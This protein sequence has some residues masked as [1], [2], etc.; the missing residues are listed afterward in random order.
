[1]EKERQNNTQSI[2]NIDAL[3][4]G[5]LTSDN[6][7]KIFSESTD[8]VNRNIMIKNQSDLSITL[9]YVDGMANQKIINDNIICPLTASKWYENCTTLSQ[10]FSLSLDGALDVSFIKGTQSTK[11]AVEAIL[12]GNTILVFDKLKSAIIMSTIGFDKRAVSTAMEE[13]TY[14][15]GKDGF[16]ETLRMNT[17]ALRKKIKNPNLCIKEITIG[18]QSNTRICIAYMQNICNEMFIEEIK[19]RIA[20]I[21]QDKAISIRDIYSN[22][23]KEKYTPFPIATVTEKPDVCCMSLLEGKVAV[24]V[25]ELPYALVLPAVF[26]DFFQSSSDYGDNFL[27]ASFFRIIRY[28]CFYVS[29]LLPGFFVAVTAFHPEMIPYS[30]AI[31]IAASRTGTPFSMILEILI[32]SF[33]FFVLIQAS[34]QLSRAIGATISIVGGL[35]L[36]QAAITAGIVSPAVIV[37]VATAAICSM[38]IPDKEVNS[39]IWLFQLLCTLCSA[40]LGLMGVVLTLIILF[41]MLAKLSPLGVPYLSPYTT[42][43]DLQL[44][45]SIVRFP[46]NLIK[47]RPLYLKPK[48]KRRKR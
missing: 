42:S 34:L 24:I 23:V 2:N 6:L 7:K 31:K 32:M 13:N 14:R 11:E 30:L 15:C 39:A 3:L 22:V 25:D 17:A 46:S 48:N 27:V 5:E 10:A 21:N 38:A 4:S 29:I 33:A 44:A 18:K 37:V 8:I 28:I 41:F 36:G 26:G 43:G 47:K 35:V 40:F 45:D 20:K 19:K 12:V 9:F 16:V 1:M